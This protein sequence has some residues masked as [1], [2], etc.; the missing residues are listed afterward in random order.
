MDQHTA[1][2]V[3]FF[4]YQIAVFFDFAPISEFC[5]I[6]QNARTGTMVF[7]FPGRRTPRNPLLSLRLPS[8]AIPLGCQARILQSKE[9]KK[10]LK[11]GDVERGLNSPA[12]AGWWW[13]PCRKKVTAILP[14]EAPLC[15][16]VWLKAVGSEPQP[17]GQRAFFL[18]KRSNCGQHGPNAREVFYGV[19]GPTECQNRCLQDVI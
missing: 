8:R 15:C 18:A 17:R 10:G 16:P 4:K 1:I 3:L 19:T 13:G 6:L 5:N 12:G 9:S 11:T 2:E 7:L 14:S